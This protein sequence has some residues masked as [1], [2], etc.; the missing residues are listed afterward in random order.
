MTASVQE[1][2]RQKYIQYLQASDMRIGVKRFCNVCGYRFEAFLPFNSRPD[3]RCPVCGSLERHR[4]LFVH[5]NSMIPFLSGRRILHFAPERP[6]QFAL[7]QS[8]AEY[9]DADIEPGRASLQ[10]D[11]CAISFADG[12]F[13]YVIAIHVLEHIPDDFKALREIYRVLKPGGRAILMVPVRGDE[14]LEVEGVTSPEE[15][16]R[17]YGQADHLRMYGLADFS[18]KIESAGFALSVSLAGAF[19]EGMREEMRLIDEVFLAEKK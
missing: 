15:R 5:L 4:H 9:Y 3:A 11:I 16:L 12:F 2:Y 14:T 10:E 8:K 6:V 17:L 13:D 19:P 18:R 7:S 1:F